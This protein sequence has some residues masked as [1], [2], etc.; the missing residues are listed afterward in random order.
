MKKVDDITWARLFRM[1]RCV[2]C[3][4]GLIYRWG[5]A[6]GIVQYKCEAEECGYR[7]NFHTKESIERAGQ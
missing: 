1:R 3:G 6:N 5:F 2:E 7:R 4:G